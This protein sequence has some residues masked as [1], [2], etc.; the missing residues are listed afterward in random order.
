MGCLGHT[1]HSHVHPW[2]K[3]ISRNPGPQM[4]HCWKRLQCGLKCKSDKRQPIPEKLI[5][6]IS[7]WFHKVVHYRDRIKNNESLC[8]RP[9]W[10]LILIV[11]FLVLTTSMFHILSKEKLVTYN[12]GN[13][14]HSHDASYIVHLNGNHDCGLF[15]MLDK[16]RLLRIQG[17]SMWVYSTRST[18]Q[19]MSR[20]NKTFPFDC[21]VRG[22]L[23][24]NIK[25]CEQYSCDGMIEMPQ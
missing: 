12:Q 11:A 10:F 7:W 18:N 3:R 17:E 15:Q 13:L 9:D 8:F 16:N 6:K 24:W 5:A 25:H 14:V 1:M 21:S 2:Q 22:R 23:A 4:C 19:S 20:A